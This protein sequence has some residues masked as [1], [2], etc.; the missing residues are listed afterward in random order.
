MSSNISA[1]LDDWYKAKLTINSLEKRIQQ[2]KKSLNRYMDVRRVNS[3]SDNN[4][5]LVR[6][7]IN[8][9]TVSKKDL[10]PE[11]WNRFANRTRFPT[12]YVSKKRM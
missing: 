10:S 2:H 6:R 7:F 11:L 8:R 9:E 4:Y 1:I 5:V 3:V 12:F